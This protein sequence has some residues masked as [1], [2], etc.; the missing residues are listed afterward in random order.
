M[1][2][3]GPPM[4]RGTLADWSR[5]QSDADFARAHADRIITLADGVVVSE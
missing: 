2:P 3:K 1:S 4:D 5:S